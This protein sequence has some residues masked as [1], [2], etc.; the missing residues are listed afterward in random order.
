M[1]IAIATHHPEGDRHAG[2]THRR[3]WTALR[4]V[5]LTLPVFS[6][7]VIGCGPSD[8]SG[9]PLTSVDP[10]G[11]GSAEIG[12]N[13]TGGGPIGQ[14]EM[15]STL[16]DVTLHHLEVDLD[17]A[18]SAI[19]LPAG[20]G[21]DNGLIVA[22]RA[23]TI[24]VLDL[25]GPEPQLSDPV[26]DLT[27]RVSTDMEQGLL[28]LALSP[29]EDILYVSFTDNDGNSRLE[30]YRVS[31]HRDVTPPA[32]ALVI[33]TNSRRTLLTV[34]Q[35]YAN[36][37]GGH[38]EF[39][40]DGMLYLGLGDG[41]AGGDPHGNAQDRSTL[42]GK[43]VRLDPT[44]S[45]SGGPAPAD[46]P[47]VD[48][49]GARPE[50]WAT[51]LRNPWR[52]SFDPANGDLWI[53][54]VGQDRYE[55]INHLP[56]SEGTG[57]GANLGWDLYEGLDEFDD[58]DP[59]PSPASDGPF[60]EPAFV[61]SHGPGCSITGGIV[62][63]GRSV[64]GLVGRYLFSDLCDGQIRTLNVGENAAGRSTA[65]SGSESEAEGVSQIDLAIE[66]LQ[67]VSFAVDTMGEAYVIS[68]PNGIYR[69]ESA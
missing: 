18:I 43:M 14:D 56:A 3:R 35:P 4:L 66:V 21:I 68:L 28:G 41:G 9:A 50:I 11:S 30:S 40:P 60:V 17:S 44:G 61:Y 29:D 15:D 23:G 37:N 25:S 7:L 53:A 51:G 26:L 57:R 5:L 6:A 31:W 13:G 48:A 46:N 69:I 67:P 38:I 32:A 64:P 52:F 10:G 36:H 49:P 54:D 47:F 59:A 55:E 39:G 20:H 19:P 27:A 16:A 42:L 24:R 34:E 2:R 45:G 22:E 1:H 65:T 33:T 62:Y 58:A 63:R 12:S 8:D